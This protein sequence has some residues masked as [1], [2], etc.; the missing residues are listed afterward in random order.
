MRHGSLFS[1]YGGLSLACERVFGGTT[2]WVSDVDKGANKVLAHRFPDAPNIGDLTKVDWSSVEPVDVLEGGFPCQDLS[3]SGKRAGLRPGTRSGLW[4]H[5]AYAVSQLRPRYVVAENVRGLLS[6]EAHSDVEP[7]PWCLGE[8][9]R[10]PMRALGAVLG[11]L[12]QLGYDSRWI[13]LRASD[14]GAPHERFRVFLLAEDADQSTRVERR[15]SASGQEEGRRARPDAGRRGR[16]PAVAD[17]TDTDWRTGQFGQQAQEERSAGH[18]QPCWSGQRATSDADRKGSQ[19]VGTFSA[20]A[21]QPSDVGRSAPTEWGKY[22]PAI[23]R[24]ERVLGRLAPSP[25]EPAPKGGQRLSARFEEW[26]M[27]LDDGW[28]VDTPM[29]TDREAKKLAGN[30]VVPQQAEAALRHLLGGWE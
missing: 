14:V 17:P 5:M 18:D 30:G 1:G 9:H 12:A 7:C 11:D 28:I 10:S 26:M 19:R 3:L 8:G 16:A 23:E 27:G 2:A 4:S 6:A 15:Q 21:K 25:V 13:G 20:E 29:V 24:W 22:R